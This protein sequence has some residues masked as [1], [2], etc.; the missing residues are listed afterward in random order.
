MAAS[1]VRITVKN[2]IETLTKMTQ[3]SMFFEGWANRNLPRLYANAE[4]TRWITEGVS[5]GSQW[6]PLSPLYRERKKKLYGG[7]PGGGNVTLI[8]T[9]RMLAGILPPEERGDVVAS[10]GEEF[11]K[12]IN[13]KRII[14]STINPYAED[15]NA[16][17][18][19]SSWSSSTIKTFVKDYVS[20]LADSIRGKSGN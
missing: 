10:H 9:S 5:E 3:S 13:G 8:A 19:F 4:R 20:Y 11:R 1:G 14:F 15:V 18:D 6:K 17:R 12:L 16:V 2:N 7:Y